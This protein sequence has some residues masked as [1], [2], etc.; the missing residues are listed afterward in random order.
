[1]DDLVGVSAASFDFPPG[2]TLALFTDG[3]FE[4]A[5]AESELFGDERVIAL[6]QEGVRSRLP[7]VIAGLHEEIKRF[8][9]QD[10][11]ADDLTA[12]LIRRYD[13]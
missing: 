9:G 3:F 10:A 1:M 5:N 7:E 6:I 12:I 8:T 11:Q 13:A 4:A 2:A